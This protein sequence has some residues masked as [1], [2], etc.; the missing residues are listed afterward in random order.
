LQAQLQ[1][2]GAKKLTT[3]ILLKRLSQEDLKQEEFEPSR[4]ANIAQ[5]SDCRLIVQA[6]R[7]GG[8]P[9]SLS[10]FKSLLNHGRG[11]ERGEAP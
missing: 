1:S 9:W 8:D 10:G 7:R 2:E 3:E 11:A 4:I 5:V 6:R